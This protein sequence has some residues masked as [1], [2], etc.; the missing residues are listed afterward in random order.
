MFL[1][2]LSLSGLSKDIITL[3]SQQNSSRIEHVGDIASTTR[4]SY[5]GNDYNVRVTDTSR[6]QGQGQGQGGGLGQIFTDI[7]SEDIAQLTSLL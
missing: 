5:N 3:L 4:A 1:S 2:F 6:N 7:S